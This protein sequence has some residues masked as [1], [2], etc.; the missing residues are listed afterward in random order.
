MSK[1]QR[2]S[3]GFHR[4]AILMAAI[5]LLIGGYISLVLTPDWS[6]PVLSSEWKVVTPNQTGGRAILE[7]AGVKISMM[8]D[9]ENFPEAEQKKWADR[10]VRVEWRKKFLMP[11]LTALG[12][13][14]GVSLAVYGL[15]RAIGWVIGGFMTS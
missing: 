5:P 4:L 2:V 6:A 14:L 9:F 12:L 13:T 7:V 10:A 15:V 8:P 3:R 11:M 1:S